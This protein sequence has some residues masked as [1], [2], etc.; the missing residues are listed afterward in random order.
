MTVHIPTH[1]TAFRG[2]F[3]GFAILPGVF[4]LQELILKPIAERRS[5]LRAPL[6]LK[7]VK[8]RK[9]IRPGDDVVVTLDFPASS[10]TVHFVI[11]RREVCCAQGRVNFEGD[12][13][14]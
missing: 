9:P 14:S 12:S 10:P 13:S 11:H 1:L 3:P 7:G 2:H 6:T 5:E 8:F 4:Q